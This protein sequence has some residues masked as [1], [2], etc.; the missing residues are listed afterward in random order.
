METQRKKLDPQTIRFAATELILTTGST[1]PLDV[2]NALR[3]R[4]YEAHQAD[5]A[6]WLLVIC[7]YESWHVKD[8]GQ[9]KVYSFPRIAP[10]QEM[11]N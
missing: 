4:G 10:T 2:R 1:T 8:N 5:I 7:F 6:E 3:R 9:H 11:V